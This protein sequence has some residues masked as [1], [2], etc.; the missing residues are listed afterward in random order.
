MKR[1]DFSKPVTRVDSRVYS[2]YT[3]PN[4]NPTR[5]SQHVTWTGG[6]HRGELPGG[7]L[8]GDHREKLQGEITGGKS[9]GGEFA[10]S[11]VRIQQWHLHV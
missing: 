4:T 9:P 3:N 10:C 2:D 7:K 5:S 8:R 11:G 6:D 1:L